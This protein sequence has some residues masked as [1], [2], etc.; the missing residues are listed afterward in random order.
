MQR[1]KVEQAEAGMVTAHPIEM[2]NGQILCAK[3][4]EL[5]APVL[6]RLSKLEISHIIVEG[7]PVDDGKPQKTPEEELSNLDQRFRTVTDHKIMQA[8]KMVVRK[9]ILDKHRRAAEEE[10]E[11]AP[12]QEEAGAE[13]ETSPSS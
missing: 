2:S 10:S 5:T 6:A 8:L 4:T 7:H 11:E 3:S 12:R 9:Y 13:K 1:I